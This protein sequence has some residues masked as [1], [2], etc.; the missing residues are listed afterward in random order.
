MLAGREAF[1]ASP[2]LDLV[3]RAR[4]GDA[5]AFEELLRPRIDRLFRVAAAILRNEADAR[6]VTQ[7]TCLAA[8]RQL[9][10]LRNAG[11]FDIWLGRTLVNCCRMHLRRPRRVREIS[12]EAPVG[13]PSREPSGGG[14]V[15]RFTERDAIRSAFARLD[16]D[17]RAL[18]V[19]HHLEGQPVAEIGRFL[20]IPEGTV[21]WRLHAARAS[22]EHA[23][24][25]EQR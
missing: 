16:P 8:W 6:D 5:D 22:L 13:R 2:V 17:Q 3:E 4:H 10:R 7:D 15:D 11:A 24:K 20:G 14:G 25:V 9:P 12:I 18:L 19:L 21:K 1:I 23:L